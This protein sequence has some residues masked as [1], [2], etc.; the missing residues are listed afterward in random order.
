MAQNKSGEEGGGGGQLKFEA[1]FK[2]YA[3]HRFEL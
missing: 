1:I 3:I 2:I